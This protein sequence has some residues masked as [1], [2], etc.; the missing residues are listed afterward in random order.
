MG[1]IHIPE[2][3]VGRVGMV[4]ALKKVAEADIGKMVIVREPVG[5]VTSLVGSPKP[6]F[7]WLVQVM[8][9]PIECHGKPSHSIYV[10]D[11]CLIP[12]SEIGEMDVEQLAYAQGKAEF[13]AALE[14]LRVMI[15]NEEVTAADLEQFVDQAGEQ[16]F[17]ERSLELVPVSQA[18]Q[19][20]GFYST[21]G[22]PDCLMWVG[23]NEGTELHF[24]AGERWA[25]NWVIVGRA[26]TARQAIWDERVVTS[27]APRGKIVST[28]LGIWRNTFPRAPIPDCLKIGEVYERHQALMRRLDV[29]QLHL[30]VDPRVFRHILRWLRPDFGHSTPQD[31]VTLSYQ[32]GML[33]VDNGGSVF[34]CPAWGDWVDDC[35]VYLSDLLNLRRVVSRSRSI[36]I[37][38]AAD[39]IMVNG[40]FLEIQDEGGK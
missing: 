14:E 39:H 20:I 11:Q 23:L 36:T 22:T 26:N 28:V 40:N 7:A 15:E 9:E 27:E 25:A 37:N 38:Q 18:L 29:R 3:A 4:A 16:A 33:R 2:N 34:G 32:E 31:L 10:P 1:A 6:I 8:G 17:F 12:V 24:S 13:D 35:H 21:P 5:M 30:H 19:E